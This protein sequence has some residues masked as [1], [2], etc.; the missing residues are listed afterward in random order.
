MIFV[1]SKKW[2]FREPEVG[3]KWPLGEELGQHKKA[4]PSVGPGKIML[5]RE[6][7]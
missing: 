2:P 6:E 5:V 1:I 3:L 7:E 4:K